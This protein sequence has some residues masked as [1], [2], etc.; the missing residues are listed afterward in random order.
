M[1]DIGANKFKF[2]S[3]GV[4]VAEIDN[5]RLPAVRGPVGP[6]IIGR[7]EKGPAL[8]PVTVSS[9]AEFVEIFGNPMPGGAGGDVWRD[10][11]KLAPT[12]GAYAAQAWLKNNNSLTFVRLLGV[13]NADK[14]TG[15]EAGW[16]LGDDASAK[17]KGGAFGLFL[18]DSGSAA[19]NL[20]G[21]LAAI[22]YMDSGFIELSGSSR[23]GSS[24]TG[25]AVLVGNAGPDKEFKAL[26]KDSTGT[27]KETVT[28]NF[29]STS[30]KYI[31]NVFNTNPTLTN[32]DI[33]DSSILKNYFLGETFDRSVEEK[34]SAGASANTVWGVILAINSGSYQQNDQQMN[35]SQCSTGWFISQ[36]LA[37][38]SSGFDPSTMT[39]LFRLKSHDSGEWEQKSL[40]VSIT[41]LK[42]SSNPLNPYG[43]FTVLVRKITDTDA[44][45]EVVE[46][47][48][49][50]SLDPASSN[51]VAKKIGDMF[52]QWD[53]DSKR[54]REIGNYSNKSKYFYVEMNPDVDAGATNSQLLPFGFFGP[55][56]LKGF[57]AIS[58][59]TTARLFGTPATST[60]DVMVK[61]GSN[62]VSSKGSS[63]IE[64]GSE[65]FTGSFVFG[66]ISL[67][68]D[69]KQGNLSSPKQAFFGIDV[70][71]KGTTKFDKSITDMV[72]KLPSGLSETSNVVE[73][74]FVF[75]LDDVKPLTVGSTTHASWVSGSRAAGTS[76]TS[77]V[78]GSLSGS[79]DGILKLGFDRFTAPLYGGFDGVDIT[80]KEPFNNRQLDDS[81]TEF[82][83]Y[84]FNSVAR[85]ID[86]VSDPELVE[87]SILSVPGITHKGLTNRV[88]NV[89]ETRRDLLAIIDIP[90]GYVPASERS[91]GAAQEYLTA[92]IGSVTTAI[93]SLTDREINN[94]YGATYYPWVQVS[95]LDTGAVVW[96]PPSVVAIGALSYTER[97]ADLWIA[98]AGFT[99]GGLSN[100]AA[101]IPVLNVKQ[102]LSSTERDKLYNANI[103]PIASFPAEGIVILGQ[104]TLQGYASATDR[105][106]VRR[107]LN[108]LKVEVSKIAATLLFDP[109]LQV[110][111]NRFHSQVSTLLKSV[112]TRFGL[113]DWKVVLD[114]STTT[115]DL[116]DRNTMY[117]KIYLKPARAI[118]FIG[119]DFVITNSGASFN[120]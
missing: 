87:C 110:T 97:N 4:Q 101:G 37:A 106:N 49:D 47:F 67:R 72:R 33:T 1:A 3:P 116:V 102:K 48:S 112:E 120:D 77:L 89:A 109:N 55:P 25:T 90:G 114:A 119:I 76:F 6:V 31:R 78:S 8:K 24:L 94:S 15:G 38:A 64:V 70:A 118:E 57:T 104:K 117:A 60:S 7:T 85:A 82:N 50:C 12:Y 19:S 20:T 36:D 65:A 83:S 62:I 53:S 79:Y 99:R 13:E 44:N 23:G 32:T 14:E 59:S 39:K 105:I 21:T 66:G 58:G 111:W 56:R 108:Y 41:D 73:Y 16:V 29:K 46:R 9:F 92:N 10:G 75:T 63:L 42:A 51:Y 40:K 103:N 93:D 95:D 26:V 61:G 45:P 34:I 84:I 68:S 107:L 115:P 18:I 81:K 74:G 52:M 35:S 91:Q 86:S 28:F 88:L 17:D 80:E 71:K 69:T 2:V 5:S 100:G 54:Y 113:Q 27:L 11:N 43:S 98:P 30:K 22:F 96:V